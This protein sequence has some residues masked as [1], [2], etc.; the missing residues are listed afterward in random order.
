MPPHL[1]KDQDIQLGAGD[2][3][4]VATPGG[5][6]YGDP[7]TRDPAL[8]LHDVAWAITP[9]AGEG[10]I[11]SGDRRG[12]SACGDEGVP[13]PVLSM[14]KEREKGMSGNLCQQFRW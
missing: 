3:V 1:S 6:G 10:T 7:L 13:R 2:V 4:R 12:R 11:W 5:G 9:R 8:V 14:S